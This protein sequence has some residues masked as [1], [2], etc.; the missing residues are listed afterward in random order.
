MPLSARRLA[1]NI[2]KAVAQGAY[3]D[4]ALQRILSK[5]PHSL[6][7]KLATELAYGCIRRQRTLDTLIDQFATKLAKDQPPDLR[8]VL[9]LGF[10]QLRYLDQIPIPAA[11]HATVELAKEL[12]LGR[13]TK[14][15]NGILR[16]YTRE[17]TQ[18]DPLV[19]PEDEIQKL[20][21]RHSFPDWMVEVWRDQIGLT[22]TDHLCAWLSSTPSLD[23]RINPLKTSREAVQSALD[24]AG[25]QTTVIPNLPQGLRLEGAQGR[26]SD[27][28]GFEAGWWMVQEAGAQLV[29]HLLHPQP[30]WTVLDLCAAPG[31]KTLHLAELMQGRGHIWACDPTASR[32][33]RLDQNLK[34]LQ[35]DMVQTWQG[36]GRSLPKTVPPFDA[37]L[38]DAPCSGLGTLHRHADARWRQSPD[39]IQELQ[40]LQGEL[41]TSAASHVKSDGILV[42]ATCTLHPDENEQVVHQFLGA[43][44]HWN[45][46][47]FPEAFNLPCDRGSDSELKLWPH[48]HHMDGFYMA[49]LRRDPG[50]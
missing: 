13:L 10:Y 35:V 34:R 17:N 12:N 48:Q 43:N 46:D 44:P 1:F 9:Q 29:S 39:R 11:I 37:A 42:Y 15:V 38:V 14:V 32:L 36:D 16:Q 7:R 45:L 4:V 30:D 24:A 50:S 22:E 5:E 41:L 27:L 28:P 6:D 19:L 33:R 8:I 31:G 40:R 3:A 25:V 18:A 23:L 49:R 47:P 2:I 26:I 21:I 20:G